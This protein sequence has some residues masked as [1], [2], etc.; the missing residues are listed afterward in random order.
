MRKYHI[1]TFG[2]QMNEHD[3]EII[4]GILEERGFQATDSPDDA[5]LIIFNTCCVRENPERKVYGRLGDLGIPEDRSK[6]YEGKVKQGKVLAVTKANDDQVNE[7]K[8]IYSKFG[9]SDIEIH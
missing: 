1:H 9:A 3:S 4:A 8:D 7:V 2:C 5:D 6:F